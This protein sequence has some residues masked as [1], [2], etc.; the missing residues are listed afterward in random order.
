MIPGLDTFV[1]NFKEITQN[2][3]DLYNNDTTQLRQWTEKDFD[4]STI[5]A[6][7]DKVDRIL[8]Y[9]VVKKAYDIV[10]AY[11]RAYKIYLLGRGDYYRT[12]IV[13]RPK[14]SLIID[15]AVNNLHKIFDDL[16]L[17]I[18]LENGTN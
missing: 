8:L 2:H 10:R 3:I 18:E 14:D 13:D 4:V 16:K 9:G 1:S 15:N 7:L 11:H 17:K 6:E 5:V 12:A